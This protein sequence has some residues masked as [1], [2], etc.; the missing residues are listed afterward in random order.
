MG[1][2]SRI[3][4]VFSKLPNPKVN[5]K[6]QKCWW[7]VNPGPS[8]SEATALPTQPPPVPRRELS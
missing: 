2:H 5:Y 7:N 1:H 6:Q 8:L 3:L 4:A